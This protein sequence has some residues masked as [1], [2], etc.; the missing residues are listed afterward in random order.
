[1][2]L[3]S[4]T[5]NK[6]HTPGLY[7]RDYKNDTPSHNALNQDAL[8]QGLRIAQVALPFIALYKPLG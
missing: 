8:N 2:S 6:L 3:M 4:E 1:M 7:H 5:S